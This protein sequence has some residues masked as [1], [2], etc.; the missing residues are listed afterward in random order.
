VHTRIDDSRLPLLVETGRL[1]GVSNVRSLAKLAPQRAIAPCSLY[2]YIDVRKTLQ[3]SLVAGPKLAAVLAFELAIVLAAAPGALL[4]QAA[5]APAGPPQNPAI[6][7][8]SQVHR[9]LT[10]TAW[11]VF[12]GDTP[13]PM[14]V[15]I[16]GVL[17]GARGPGQDMILAR[18]HGAK[19]E[20]TGVV[21]GMSGSP[22][23]IDGKLL[24]S[25]SYRIGIFSKEPIAGITP[26]K[27]LLEVR[28][29]AAHDSELREAVS[30]SSAI[31]APTALMSAFAAPGPAASSSGS[32]LPDPE[33]TFQPMET[34]LVMSGFSPDAIHFWQQHTEGT[35]L[36]TIS[37]GGSADGA[38][39]GSS[40]PDSALI[41]PPS[42]F[43]PGSAVSMQLV[44]GDLEISG[45]CTVTYVD[46]HQLL[47]CGHPVLQAGPVSLP[48]TTADVIATLPSPLNAFKIIN[49]GATIGA[50]TEDRASAIRGV[51]GEQA[52]MIPMH[53]SVDDPAGPRKVNVEIL[54]LPSLTPLAMQVVLYQSLLQSNESSASLSY[55][56]TGAID[57]AGFPSVPLDE[58]SP[59]DSGMLPAPMMAA[60]Q[61]GIEFQQLYSNGARQGSVRQIDLHVEAV[62]RH[63]QVTLE[64]ARVVSS[65]LIHA[66]DTVEIEATVRPWQQAERNVRVAVKL[67][68]RLASGN[69]RLLVSDGATLDR[70]LLQ[71]HFGTGSPPAD[72]ESMLAEARNHHPVDRIYVSLLA[73]ETQGEIGGQTLTSLPLSVA[74]ALEPLR[75]AQDASLNG[76]SAE[77]AGDA[78]AGGVLSGFQVLNVHIE[79]GGGL[80]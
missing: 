7:P 59:A 18:L 51:F 30:T 9:G 35:P 32:A 3:A 73:P 79:P 43:G 75:N 39:S 58:W 69:L 31:A 66:G 22:V 61:A 45:T 57:L 20:Y 13:E 63:V 19:P 37:A 6:F 68:A 72:L 76:E 38:A 14:Q 55:H 49:T 4:A 34:P 41:T 67:P 74:N 16:L 50:F 10:G 27:D 8:L 21:E 77:L 62:S 60:L 78:P 2:S 54:D 5:A 24:G 47:A 36:A 53:I 29:L 15:E 80:N 11:T 46:P 40:E 12:E 28:D 17:R 56:V 1:R 52:H 70:T 71:P 25:L 44:R 33:T 48:M 64:Q 26:I 23:Y 65:N 42:T